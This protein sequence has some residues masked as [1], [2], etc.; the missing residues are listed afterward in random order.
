MR[1][2][3]F[4]LIFTTF[5]LTFRNGWR[6]TNH[7]WMF[8]LVT[9]SQTTQ[10]VQSSTHHLSPSRVPSYPDKG[11]NIFPVTCLILA[12]FLSLM[13]QFLFNGLNRS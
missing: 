12:S 9:V 1:V 5:T 13:P 8:T 6:D 3:G 2:Q 11:T 10:H 7:W 4:L